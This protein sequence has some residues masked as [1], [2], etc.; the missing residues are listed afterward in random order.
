M[1]LFVINFL[2]MKTAVDQYVINMVKKIREE[3]GYSQEA[4]SFALNLSGSFISQFENGK[5]TYNVEQLNNIAKVLKCS[6][7]IFLPEDA[8]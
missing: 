7:R 8:I 1:P 4:L 5:A 6:P 3:K 2:I